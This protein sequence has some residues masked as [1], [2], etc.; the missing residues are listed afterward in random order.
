MSY[1]QV[2]SERPKIQHTNNN[3]ADISGQ[4]TMFLNEFKNMFNQLLNQNT[5]MLTMLTTIIKNGYIMNSSMELQRVK[6]SYL[7][8]FYISK[9]QTK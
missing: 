5:M 7:R 3:T 2:A 4:L 9:K 8:D 1:S 6:Q